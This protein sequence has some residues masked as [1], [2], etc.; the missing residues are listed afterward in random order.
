MREYFRVISH[1]K[2]E[3]TTETPTDEALHAERLD[4]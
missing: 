4:T 2:V 1:A 3:T